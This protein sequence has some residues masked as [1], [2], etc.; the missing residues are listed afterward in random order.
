MLE[1]KNKGITLI[2][3]LKEPKADANAVERFWNWAKHTAIKSSDELTTPKAKNLRTLCQIGNIAF[4]L[5]ALGILIPLYTRT[6]TNKRHAQE[7]AKQGALNT[8]STGG[9]SGQTSKTSS[10]DD[11][12]RSTVKDNTAFSAIRNS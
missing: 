10:N 3:R 11:F 8:A 4:S 9:A 5:V 6:T 2:N 1:K 7:L 12:L